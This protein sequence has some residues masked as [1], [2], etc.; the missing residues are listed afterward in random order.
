MAAAATKQENRVSSDLCILVAI[1]TRLL[2]R[3]LS[4]E[5]SICEQGTGCTRN[6]KASLEVRELNEVKSAG[7]MGIVYSS[8]NNLLTTY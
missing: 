2:L 8:G 5:A 3:V 6:L 1:V 4:L 7:K